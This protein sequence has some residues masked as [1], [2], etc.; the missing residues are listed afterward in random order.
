MSIGLGV[1]LLTPPR[2]IHEYILR[3]FMEELENKVYNNS[4]LSHLRR[5]VQFYIQKFIELQPEYE[6]LKGSQLRE[7]LGIVDTDAIDRIIR[8]WVQGVEITSSRPRIVGTQIV[9]S[10]TIQAVQQDYSDVLASGAAKFLTDKD[11]LIPWLDWLLN[12]GSDIIIAEYEV[13]SSP[14]YTDY[15]R[16]GDTLMVK[17]GG[18]WRVP[19]AFAGTADN[20]FITRA[21]ND[22]LPAIEQI[23]IQNIQR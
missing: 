18:A 2:L 3:A 11:K 17:N 22:A 21:I 15:S 1:K 5:D 13:K 19:S 4:R 20:N 6:S 14:Q 12:R 7:E 23:F 8:I 10:I 9:G 16:T